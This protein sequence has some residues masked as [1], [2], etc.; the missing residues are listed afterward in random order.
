M[1]RI[2]NEK[3]VAIAQERIRAWRDT[4]FAKNDVRIQNALADGDEDARLQAVLYRE[5]LRNLPQACIG[6]DL[7]ELKAIMDGVMS[8]QEYLLMGGGG[9]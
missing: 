4:A 1:L 3:A 2:N 5:Y 7:D 8:Y 9:E 6:K